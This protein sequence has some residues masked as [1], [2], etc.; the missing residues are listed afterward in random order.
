MPQ[1]GQVV[2]ATSR[3]FNRIEVNGE[4][5]IRVE[6]LAAVV[7]EDAHASGRGG[8]RPNEIGGLVRAAARRI[9]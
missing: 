5:Y 8:F 9:E 6:A 7:D 1:T 2:V 3:T 4:T